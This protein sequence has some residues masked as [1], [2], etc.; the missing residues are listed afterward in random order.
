[1]IQKYFVD[2]ETWS[3]FPLALGW[4]ENDLIFIFWGEQAVSTIVAFVF[5]NNEVHLCWKIVICSGSQE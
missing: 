3:G 4:I 5:A 1:M 2:K